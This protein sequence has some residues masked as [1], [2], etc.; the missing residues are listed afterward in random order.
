MPENET[1][2][3]NQLRAFILQDPR[4]A[5]RLAREAGIDPAGLSRFLN[6]KQGINLESADRLAKLLRLRLVKW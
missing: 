2:I 4:S 1:S 3:S 5:S 6:G